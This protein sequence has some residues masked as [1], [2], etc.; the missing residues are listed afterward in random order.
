LQASLATFADG[1]RNKIF[2]LLE[3]HVNY[4]T[5][6]RIENTERKRNSILT[7][8]SGRE[9]RHRV[10]LSSTGLAKTVRINYESMLSIQR[11]AHRLEE[12]YLERVEQ[13]AVLSVREM[14]IS[15]AQIQHTPFVRP[16]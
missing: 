14:R 13:L 10:K 5:L 11:A 2:F 9:F 1:F 15:A 7:N 12:Q 8:M 16:L 6:G 4:A 3:R